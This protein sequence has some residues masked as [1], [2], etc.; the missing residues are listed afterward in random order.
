MFLLVAKM[1]IGL[2]QPMIHF[3]TGAW[4][5]EKNPP[6]R[7]LSWRR[8]KC[9]RA[10]ALN[11]A[12]L[13]THAWPCFYLKIYM[14]HLNFTLTCV[15]AAEP[16]LQCWPGGCGKAHDTTVLC[17]WMLSV[18]TS[19]LRDGH[20]SE[21]KN[22]HEWKQTVRC[23]CLS[24][25]LPC[26][27]I[28][29]HAQKAPADGLALLRWTLQAVDRY[30]TTLGTRRALATEKPGCYMCSELPTVHRNMAA[31]KPSYERCFVYKRVHA[32]TWH[33]LVYLGGYQCSQQLLCFPVPGNFTRPSRNCTCNKKYSA[34]GSQVCF[35]FGPTTYSVYL[36]NCLSLGSSSMTKSK[37]A[38][39]MCSTRTVAC[40]WIFIGIYACV[41][42]CPL[43][44]AR[45]CNMARRRL[46]RKGA[47]ACMH[48]CLKPLCMFMWLMQT[49]VLVNVLHTF[50]HL[51]VHLR[52]AG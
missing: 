32:C 50:T 45:F 20:D 6:W 27:N 44:T 24:F 41:C 15:G 7:N 39:N 51:C 43:L 22:T 25:V 30:F 2:L 11:H 18:V 8:S 12:C 3:T 49:P 31:C 10:L 14:W 36:L 33:V 47:L 19:Q 38:P 40:L 48:A 52:F 1:K 16:R 9:L 35:S 42:V 26:F 34:C 13:C 17:Q 29:P 5:R 23:C 37:M 4:L 21:L 28:K 46:D